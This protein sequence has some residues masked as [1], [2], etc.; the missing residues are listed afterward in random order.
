M[1]DYGAFA[2]VVGIAGSLAAA[3]SAITLAFK[4]RARWQPPEETVPAAVARISSLIAMVFVGLI[5]VFAKS[6]GALA[7]A[8]IAVVCLAVSVYAL[9]QAIKTNGTYS[10]YYPQDTEANRKLGGDALTAEASNIMKTKKLTEQQLF[11]DAQ[12]GKDLVWTKASQARVQ[13]RSALS[14]I[15]LIAF[16]TCA[17]AATAMLVAVYG[18]T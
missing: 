7:L 5:Y 9:I 12:G 8:V 16:G 15:G 1:S 18:G 14:F 6:I 10:F 3:A 13:L 17:L 4:K 2:N 11:T